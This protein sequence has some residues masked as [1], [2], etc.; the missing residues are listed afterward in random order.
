MSFSRLHYDKCEQKK[1]N[2]QSNG[3]G[4]YSVN[5]PIICNN[6]VQENPT[7]QMQKTGVSMNSGVQWRFYDGPVDV[8]SDLRNINRPLTRCPDIKYN[9][10]CSNVGCN[11][12]GHPCGQ[13][14][15]AGCIPEN[16]R[17]GDQNLVNFPSCYLQTDETRLNN[18]PSNLRGTGIN[19][20]DPLCLDPQHNIEFPGDFHVPTRL[21]VKDNHRPCVPTPAV[22]DM[23][24]PIKKL[25]CDMTIPVCANNTK[26]LYQYDVCG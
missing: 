7:I 18:P 5:T 25:P 17:N 1:A 21:V 2:I 9:P 22:N 16:K 10:K 24:P 8:E 19:R 12:Q 26:A 6:C 3:P 15:V 23:I 14:V 13:G 20:F 4:N 11:N